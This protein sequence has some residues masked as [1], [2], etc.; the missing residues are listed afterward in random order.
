MGAKKTSQQQKKSSQSKRIT[1]D[2][3]LEFYKKLQPYSNTQICPF[4][5]EFKFINKIEISESTNSGV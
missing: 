1:K 2:R 3:V 4:P 5:C